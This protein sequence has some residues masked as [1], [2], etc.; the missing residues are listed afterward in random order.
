MNEMCC[1]IKKGI[2]FRKA[3][4]VTPIQ[5][6]FSHTHDRSHKPKELRQQYPS[7]G[8]NHVHDTFLSLSLDIFVPFFKSSLFDLFDKLTLLLSAFIDAFALTYFDNL[9]CEAIHKRLT[10]L[11]KMINKYNSPNPLESIHDCCSHR[12]HPT[13]ILVTFYFPLEQEH[14]GKCRNYLQVASNSQTTFGTSN[15][16]FNFECVFCSFYSKKL[17]R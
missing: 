11:R 7:A 14:I 15:F 17:F 9:S 10:T 5:M 2:F 3:N 6:R 8:K 16:Y 1:E 13:H 4:S 12:A